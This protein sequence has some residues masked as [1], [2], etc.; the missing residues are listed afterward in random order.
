V[1]LFNAGARTDRPMVVHDRVL[2]VANGITA[3]RLL[4]LPLFVW[5]AAGIGAYG[6][7]FLTLVVVGSTD[8]VDG[9]VARRFD[10]VTKLGK[11]IDPLIDRAM[12][13]TA[14]FTLLWLGFIP[15][16]I[17]ALVVGRDVAL[18]VAGF[19]MFRGH[20]P[21]IPVS[22][23][24]KFATACLLVGVPGF[25]LARMDWSGAPVLV[26]LA[27]GFSLVGI[28]TYYVAGWQYARA[29]GQVR[30]ALNA[31]DDRAPA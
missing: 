29:A 11:L 31:A 28:A 24:G 25:L 20:N 22:N 23:M 2:T 8:W 12:L 26:V 14:A 16:W 15:W 13:A 27:Y 9:Y 6:M 7:A 1:G 30:R 5:L 17:V 21:N 18:L 19:L 10:Q 4:G 3:V